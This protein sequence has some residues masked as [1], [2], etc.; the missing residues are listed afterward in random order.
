M[1]TSFSHRDLTITILEAA[2]TYAESSNNNTRKA[3]GYA[4]IEGK[5]GI[6]GFP[7][8]A[9]FTIEVTASAGFRH[10][11][12]DGNTTELFDLIESAAKALG[13]AADG[14][15]AIADL[16]HH[17]FAV[18]RVREKILFCASI[19]T[20]FIKDVKPAWAGIL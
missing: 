14:D 12:H 4:I 7:G 6:E 1:L 20:P 8:V 2:I 13:K 17:L 3:S 18:L 19:G 5:A 11:N 9:A 10:Y 16:P 15:E